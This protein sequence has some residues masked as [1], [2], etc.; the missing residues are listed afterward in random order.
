[1][2]SAQAAWPSRIDREVATERDLFNCAGTLYEL[3]AENAGGFAK[4][5]PVA[6]HNRLIHDFCSYRGLFIMSGIAADAPS[7]NPHVIRSEDGRAALW[8]GVL[9]DVWKL[10]KARGSGGPW[11]NSVVEAGQPSDPFLMTGFDRKTLRLSHGN[12]VSTTIT[13]ELDLTGEGVWRTYKS[14][15][16]PAG[17]EVIYE[18]PDGFGAYWLRA[19]ASAAGRATVQLKY[20]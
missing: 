13:I 17:K 15:S 7:S 8:V 9:D 18:F 20:D 6:T 2:E 16:V 5:R 12:G 4:I 1:M 10:G 14:F 19:V 11:N 3:P